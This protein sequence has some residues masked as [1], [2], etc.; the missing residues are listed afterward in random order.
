M[1][2]IEDH[3]KVL[4][5]LFVLALI[6]P[7]S[8]Q[9]IRGKDFHLPSLVSQTGVTKPFRPHEDAFIKSNA[10]SEKVDTIRKYFVPEGAPASF[11]A[12]EERDTGA[13]I[14]EKFPEDKDADVNFNDQFFLGEVD[15]MLGQAQLRKGSTGAQ[16][17]RSMRSRDFERMGQEA[18]GRV[19]P[20]AQVRGG[21]NFGSLLREYQTSGKSASLPAAGGGEGAISARPHQVTQFGDLHTSHAVL[22]QLAPEHKRQY[23]KHVDQL[24]RAGLHKHQLTAPAATDREDHPATIPKMTKEQHASLPHSTRDYIRHQGKLHSEPDKVAR[25]E[26]LN[27]K[28]VNK[29][30]MDS[31]QRARNKGY[32]V[33]D[34]V[35]RRHVSG[36]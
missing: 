30:W 28:A 4:M 6:W 5:R 35:T 29:G 33:D 1:D 36:R 22:H 8:I 18:L 3:L 10:D 7:T 15:N 9:G 14:N 17:S 31:N 23:F 24:A 11:D 20:Q 13:E 32:H 27:A 26:A 12:W 34:S 21:V 25:W 2:F 16:A 19:G